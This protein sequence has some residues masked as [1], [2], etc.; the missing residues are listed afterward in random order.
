[1]AGRTSSPY[2]N[3][4][5]RERRR[6]QSQIRRLVKSGYDVE[7]SLPSIPKRITAGSVRRLR[8]ISSAKVRAQSYA[9][10]LETGEKITFQQFKLRY[11]GTPFKPNQFS[12]KV[13]APTRLPSETELAISQV[14]S[15]FEDY[16]DNTRLLA[17]SKL[18]SAIAIY[19]ERKFGK[20]LAE[21][22]SDG[23]IITPKEAYNYQAVLTMTNTLMQLLAISDAEGDEINT[24][25][26][27]ENEA[28]EEY[29]GEFDDW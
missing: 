28:Q 15:I 1:M 20:A 22:I 6:I 26:N 8:G 24:S 16:P 21:M 5:M 7:L 29:E 18:D 27:A 11:G 4:Y 2:Y 13:I 3:E 17:L 23:E 10:D 12:N 14:R 25:I 9:P 19:G